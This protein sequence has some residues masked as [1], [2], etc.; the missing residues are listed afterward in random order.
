MSGILG[1]DVLEHSEP[2][3]NILRCSVDSMVDTIVLAR[4]KLRENTSW[5]LD[6]S[7]VSA[8][9]SEGVNGDLH[10]RFPEECIIVLQVPLDGSSIKSCNCT[11]CNTLIK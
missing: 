6:T 10:P 7:I 2:A 5:K 1:L 8:D 4:R 9:E 11:T 3:H